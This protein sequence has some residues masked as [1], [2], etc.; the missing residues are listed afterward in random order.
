MAD[1]L[2]MP[3]EAF[4]D[5]YNNRRYHESLGNVTLVDAF[6]SRD[7][8]IIKRR[9]KIKKLIIQTLRLQHQHL[10]KPIKLV[11]GISAHGYYAHLIQ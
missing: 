9:E 6:C 7:A 10:K 5:H 11:V 1:N 4:V 2:T 3:I 8:A